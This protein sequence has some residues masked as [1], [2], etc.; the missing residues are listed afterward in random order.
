KATDPENSSE[1]WD[2][3]HEFCQHVNTHTNGP[4]IAMRL[5]AHKIQSPQEKEALQALTLL[6]VCMNNCGK[7]F[8][9]EAAKFRFLN[10]L[11]KV[12]SPKYLGVCSTEQVKQRV[13]EVLYSWTQWLKDEPKVQEAYSMLKKQGI[14]KKDPRLSTTVTMPPPSPRQEV[15]V[16]D[17][18]DT[19]KLLSQ[20]LKSGRPEDLE[21]ANTLIKSTLQ[22][23]QE[24]MDKE[25]RRVSTIQEVKNC[26]SQLRLLL[27]QHHTQHTPEMQELY[28]R[29]DRLRSNLFRLAS[30]TVNNDEALAEILHRN[31][32]LTHVMTLYRE[33]T[34]KPQT[35]TD[36]VLV[37]PVKSYHL[38]DFSVLG[39]DAPCGQVE[40]NTTLLQEEEQQKIHD[41]SRTPLSVKSYL[42]D[43]LQLE[44]TENIMS[45]TGQSDITHNA[46]VFTMTDSELR[47]RSTASENQPITSSGVH[48]P[49]PLSSLAD[50]NVSLDS[51]KPKSPPSH[52]DVAVIIIS[53]VNTSP[54]PV[55]DFL[56]LA[57]VPKNMCVRLQAATGNSLPP[58]SPLLPPAALSQILLLSNPLR[59]P[60]RLR[61]RVTLTLGQ[62]R[63]Q[64]DGDIEQFP[65]WN[66]WTHI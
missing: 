62:E 39:D 51:I 2:C 53:A 59:K 1:R 7:R 64:Q 29:C 34:P 56:F 23:E 25:S 6:E 10:E 32:E 38:I 15:S 66:S 41:S 9:S 52:P 20:L 17:N 24:K 57:A 50:I 60:V 11:I 16:F 36:T 33:K 31:D 47:S 22:E 26:T 4:H 28:E 21:M 44:D 42:D 8:H 14:V 40:Q 46:S 43:L 27:N 35:E 45:E 30:D 58:F 19:S 63:L 12:L 5:L 48:K 65:Q 13:T 61:F 54:L 18:E 37:S 49:R 3:M 55:S